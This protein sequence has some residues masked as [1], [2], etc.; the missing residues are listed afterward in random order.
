MDVRIHNILLG[1]RANGPGFRN[2]VWF[3]GCTLGCPGC[4]NPQTHDTSGGY[5]VDIGE[6][7]QTL[8][9]PKHPCDGVTISGGEPFRQAKA[10]HEL[11]QLLKEQNSPT[12]IVFSGYSFEKLQIEAECAASLPFIDALIC[13]PYRQD[14]P[15]A[16]DCF[17]SSSNQELVLLSNRFHYADFTDLPLGEYIIDEKGNAILSGIKVAH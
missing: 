10:L 3:Q 1:S 8:L 15:P 9:D 12:V 2:T 13:G 6:L 4:F 7:C 5:L 16:Y 11:L 17:C 14:L